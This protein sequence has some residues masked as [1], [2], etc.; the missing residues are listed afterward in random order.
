MASELKT[1][2]EERTELR[3]CMQPGTLDHALGLAP[4]AALMLLDDIDTLLAEVERVR[5]GVAAIRRIEAAFAP[6]SMVEAC[7]AINEISTVLG[8]LETQ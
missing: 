1:T 6:V 8:P 5:A 2:E 3:N 4:K 7:R